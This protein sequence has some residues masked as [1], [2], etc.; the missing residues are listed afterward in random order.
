MLRKQIFINEKILKNKPSGVLKGG[1]EGKEV[2]M[3][4][5]KGEK[6]EALKYR[7]GGER[8]KYLKVILFLVFFVVLVT[9]F[10]FSDVS[11]VRVTASKANIRLKPTTQSE[12]ISYVPIGAVLDVIKKDGDWYF[13]KLPPDEKGIVVTGYIHQSIVEVLEEM[14]K[15]EEIKIEEKKEEPIIKKPE[16]KTKSEIQNMSLSERERYFMKTD[17]YYPTWRKKLELAEKEKKGTT[18]WIW[19][20]GGVMAIGY[21]VGPILTAAILSGEPAGN[22]LILISMGVGTLGTGTMIYG[23]VARHSKSGKIAKILEEGSIKGYIGADINPLKKQYTLT[24]TL[25]F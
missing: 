2:R 11:K 8:M 4:S 3:L 6:R 18:K 10:A 21:V 20:G 5:S 9:I 19:I 12:I 15:V 1:S 22:T 23:L 25:T 13:V 7:K 14:E 24:F 16:I 17:S